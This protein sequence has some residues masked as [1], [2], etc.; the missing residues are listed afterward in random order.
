LY[1]DTGP[2]SMLMVWLGPDIAYYDRIKDSWCVRRCIKTAVTFFYLYVQS[3]T[4][5]RAS[6]RESSECRVNG[7]DQVM[8]RLLQDD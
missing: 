3:S 2:F 8:A 7:H 4:H 5:E 1:S 6:D